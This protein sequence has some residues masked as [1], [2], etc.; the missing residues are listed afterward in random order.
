ML[1]L[2]RMWTEDYLVIRLAEFCKQSVY[3][4]VNDIVKLPRWSYQDFWYLILL[5][6]SAVVS[7]EQIV[8]ERI[9]SLNK[10]LF[11]SLVE[12][13]R[14]AYL[15]ELV[16]AGNKYRIEPVKCTLSIKYDTSWSVT[17]E[18]ILNVLFHT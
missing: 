6:L 9:P 16:N 14:C 17:G 10:T 4:K 1:D 18:Y 13:L 3:T 2:L 12:F 15:I 7:F 11:R 8:D 5:M